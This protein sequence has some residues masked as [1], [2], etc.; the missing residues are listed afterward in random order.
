[1]SP[2]VMVYDLRT[3]DVIVIIK[4]RWVN[5]YTVIRDLEDMM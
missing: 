1:M 3:Y 5:I 2:F 4:R